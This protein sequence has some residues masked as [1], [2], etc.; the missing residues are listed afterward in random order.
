[1]ARG[2]VLSA[3]QDFL[4]VE[5]IGTMG[6]KERETVKDKYSGKVQCANACADNVSRVQC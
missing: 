6:K 3:N 4:T 1:M 2:L 5:D